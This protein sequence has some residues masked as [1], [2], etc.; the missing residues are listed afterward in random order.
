ME[1]IL[2]NIP[3]VVDTEIGYAGG[4]TPHAT[5][6]Q[7][8]KG[9]TGHAEAIRVVF[10]PE[11]LPYEQLLGTF[12]RMHDPATRN[13]QGNDFGTQYRSAIF[14]F[15]EEQRRIAQEVKA[16]VE[17]SGKWKRPIVTEIVPASDFWPAEEYHQDYL[18][19]NP[20]GYTC[21]YLRD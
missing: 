21:H 6:P 2:R 12:F 17:A 7:V 13:R 5:Y 11:R 9:T 4:T 19:K 20:G 16:R 18:L 3:G 10:D 8:K 14:T 1:D 15:D